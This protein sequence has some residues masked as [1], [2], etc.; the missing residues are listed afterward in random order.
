MKEISGADAVVHLLESYGVDY[1]FGYPG[2][3]NLPL[4]DSLYLSKKIT[5]ILSRHEQ[6]AGLMANGYGRVS[7]KPGICLVTSGPGVTNLVTAL[8]DAYLDSVPMVAI[9]G[10]IAR[11]FI[12]T[13]AF[14]EVDSLNLTL[15]I[16]KHNELVY[17]PEDLIPALH[18]AFHIAN[19]GRK[20]PVLI[21]IPRDVQ[22][23]KFPHDLHKKRELL[24]YQ[25][26]TTAHIGQI[27][28]VMKALS[29][30][31]RPVL[32][33]GG[34]V[35]IANA[36]KELWQFAHQTKTPVVR[37]LMGKATFPE[38]DQLFI[39]MVGTHGNVEGNKAIAKAD[40]V[41]A[42]GTRLGDRTTLFRK[43]KFFEH[44]KL[45]HL[46]IDPAEVSKNAPAAIPVV[47]DAKETLQLLLENLSPKDFA[48]REAWVEKKNTANVLWKGD[49]G[50]T[51]GAIF[52]ELSKVDEKLHITTDVGRHQMWATHYCSN[53][54]HWPIL[55][56]GGLG[57]MGFGLPAAIGAWFADPKK[58]VINITGDGS[59][60]MNIQELIV[61]VEHSIPLVVLIVNDQ[62]LGMIRELQEAKYGSR[63]IAH[64]FP[65]T[66]FVAVA[67][68]FG[69]KGYHLTSLQQIQPTLKKAMNLG[70]PAV[71]ELDL[72]AIAR[73]Q[74]HEISVKA[75]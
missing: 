51:I 66:D 10:Q 63:Y 7:N 28:R 8:A 39:G 4:Y 37:T 3:A 42:V 43:D 61:A 40:L 59:F 36:Q 68:A 46:D 45:I 60:F 55:T 33:V 71:I 23:L 11:N 19:T 65:K 16:T 38:A 6:G 20:G 17:S 67:E 13:D 35:A 57:T 74:G 9:S 22:D 49:F 32:L 14:Q 27:K 75:G 50:D 30:A 15:S 44:A 58:K 54:L 47:G 31:E 72:S 25:P 34:G 12:G 52:Y 70:K 69:A 24:G 41:I 73:S 5:H 21:D 29:K 62:R 56:S 64:E 26:A 48:K 18:A 53:P 1:I 2:G